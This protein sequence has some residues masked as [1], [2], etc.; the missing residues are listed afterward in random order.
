MITGW[1][2]KP[3]GEV[4]TIKPPKAEARARLADAHEV[5]F[6]P[7]E[8]L[9]IGVKYL[10]PHRTRQLAEV[11]GSYTYFADGDVLL[12]KITPCFENGKLGV[13]RGL[14]NGV[15][16]G[17]SE[18]IVLRPAATLDAEF[19]YYYLSRPT[20]LEEGARIMTGAVGHKRVTKEFVES[21][22]IPLPP[23]REQRRIVA[24]LDEAFEGIATAKANAEKNL[25]NAREVFENHLE[26]VFARR[27][28]LW[29][30]TSLGAIAAIK[31]GKRVPKGY[32]LLDEDT[33]HPYLRVTDFGLRGSINMNDLRYIDPAVHAEIKN[34]IITPRDLYISIAG[35]IGRTGIIPDELDGANLTE[36]ACRL[37]FK[38][39][40]NNRFVYYYTRT[41]AFL[42]QAGLNTRTAAQPKLALSRLATIRLPLPKLE[43]QASVV[44]ALDAIA[45][46][47]EVLEGIYQSKA[48]ALDEL[49]K[50]LLHQ[51]FTGALTAKSTDKQLEAV[52]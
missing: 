7:M 14:I 36:N 15:G 21:Y 12:A 33:G 3:I 19:L 29:P 34:Y 2:S 49:K 13:A 5:S 35:T 18:Y 44:A 10:K 31:G 32:K 6:A 26:R 4:C 38:P 46:G 20:F 23:L 50:S 8:D 48:T 24:I 17:S 9:G 40:V 51:A 27:C 42:E 11:S 30:E 28:D 47:V 16:F 45:E 37:V 39:G 52:A 43:V 1:K 25:Q 41:P 22:P